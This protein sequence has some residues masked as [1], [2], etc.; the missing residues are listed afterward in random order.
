M[1]DS[2]HDPRDPDPCSIPHGMLVEQRIFLRPGQTITVYGEVAPSEGRPPTSGLVV[3]DAITIQAVNR[4]GF[5]G[6]LFT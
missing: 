2:R 5:S 1:P 4:P 3:A 6:G